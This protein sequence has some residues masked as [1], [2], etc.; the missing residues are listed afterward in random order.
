M[1]SGRR[2]AA[3]GGV[4]TP[5]RI[6]RLVLPAVVVVGALVAIRQ[7]GGSAT[8]ERDGLTFADAS[9]AD[10]LDR[11]ESSPGVRVIASFAD[12]DR[13]LCRSFV[14]AEG[15]GIACRERGGW[16]LRVI[17]GGVSLDDPAGVA[18]LERVLGRSAARMAVQ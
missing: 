16:H 15:S 18:E 17:R 14:G 4:M 12:S 6:L 10:A 5:R 2:R 13:V 9:L 1:L 11:G 8:V 7:F 3:I